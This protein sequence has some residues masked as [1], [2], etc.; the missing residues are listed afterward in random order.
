MH[1]IYDSRKARETVWRIDI[2][3]LERLGDNEG[4]LDAMVFN[5]VLSAS[6]SSPVFV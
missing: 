2:N 5:D 3:R 1:V 6:D 4:G